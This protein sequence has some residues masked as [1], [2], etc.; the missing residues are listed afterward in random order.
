MSEEKPTTIYRK[1]YRPPDYRIE[2][3]DLHF[4]LGEAVTRV[5][6][7]LS[8]RLAESIR[9]ER[10]P[11]VLCGEELALLGVWLC[12]VFFGSWASLMT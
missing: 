5:R 7:K 10:P 12:F 4:E 6:S 1:D 2:T 8:V 11:F 9:G 3:V